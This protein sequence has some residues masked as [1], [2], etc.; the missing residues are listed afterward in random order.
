MGYLFSTEAKHCTTII[1]KS[2]K[3]QMGME[4]SR[5]GKEM[6]RTQL[7]LVNSEMSFDRTFVPGRYGKFNKAAV[8]E[9]PPFLDPEHV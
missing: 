1:S 3:N 9:K 6:L 4:T 2:A 7:K 5:C 8:R